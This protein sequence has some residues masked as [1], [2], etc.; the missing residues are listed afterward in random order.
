MAADALTR[1]GG[2]DHW[3][4]AKA[5]PAPPQSA[6]YGGFTKWPNFLLRCSSRNLQP[7]PEG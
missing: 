7:F 5:L 2:G 1:R 3:A 6:V 4:N